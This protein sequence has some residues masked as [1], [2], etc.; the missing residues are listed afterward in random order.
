MPPILNTLRQIM[1]F[2][3]WIFLGVPRPVFIR[4]APNYD[5]AELK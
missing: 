4:I 5:I 2:H 3:E 1:Q